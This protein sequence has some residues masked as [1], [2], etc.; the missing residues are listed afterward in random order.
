ML[1]SN[2]R[3]KQDR[4][5]ELKTSQKSSVKRSTSDAV[6]GGV[7]NERK[8]CES[9]ISALSCQYKDKSFTKPRKVSKFNPEKP[10]YVRGEK[11]GEKP[12]DDSNVSVKACYHQSW[13]LKLWKKD[14]VTQ[15]IN[16]PFTCRTWRHAGAC[17]RYKGA[18]DFV[19][20]KN[21]LEKQPGWVY[22]VLTWPDR[23]GNVHEIYKKIGKCFQ[24]LRQWIKRNYSSDGAP[25]KYIFLG[26]QHRDGW[27]HVNV[28]IHLPEFQAAAEE[29]WKRLRSKVRAHAMATG[30]GKVFWLEPVRSN[31]MIAGY[32]VK[33]C[34]E[35]SKTLQAPMAAP[36]KFRRL[37]ASRGTLEP[38][39]KSE[40]YT[41]ELIQLEKDIAEGKISPKQ[42]MTAYLTGQELYGKE[43]RA[44][45]LYELNEKQRDEFITP[46]GLNSA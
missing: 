10:P 13:T 18:Q 25:L 33:L 37:R 14:D 30:W 22:I 19:R 24:N 3:P 5:G 35:V 34:Q 4:Y 46:F 45:I 12:P 32:F 16:V 29:N 21:A 44:R 2:P 20:I 15:E 36:K 38:I 6:P 40:D 8:S 23:T 39:S 31:E 11:H 41:G 26:E 28:L 7:S 9:K 17:R 27:P 42:V 43:K 1:R